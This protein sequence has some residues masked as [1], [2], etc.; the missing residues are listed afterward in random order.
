MPKSQNNP[1]KVRLEDLP[2]GIYMVTDGPS[3][4]YPDPVRKVGSEWLYV[5]GDW[6]GWTVE[7]PVE[8]Y[9]IIS[10][11]KVMKRMKKVINK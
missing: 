11:E 1:K 8:F 2:D 3:D 6:H 10:V 4:P 5:G 9:S 7:Q